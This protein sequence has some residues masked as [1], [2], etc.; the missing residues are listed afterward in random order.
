MTN[1]ERRA[2]IHRLK[3]LML[4][5]YSTSH[6]KHHDAYKTEDEILRRAYLFEGQAYETCASNLSMLI[7]DMPKPTSPSNKEDGK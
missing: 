3:A 4:S 6:W 5:W 1:D 2:L 7:E